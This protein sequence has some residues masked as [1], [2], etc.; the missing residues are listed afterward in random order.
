[1][2]KLLVILSF[3]LGFSTISFAQDTKKVEIRTTYHIK[4]SDSVSIDS[5]VIVERK[6]IPSTKDELAKFQAALDN[7]SEL[8]ML[9]SKLSSSDGLVKVLTIRKIFD[10]K[11]EIQKQMHIVFPDYKDKTW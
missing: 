9:R 4:V 3:V 11:D 7:D 8:K 10:R 6:N 5:V 2:K 1:M